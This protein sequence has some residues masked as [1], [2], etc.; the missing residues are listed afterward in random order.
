MLRNGQ[1]GQPLG[2]RYCRSYSTGA[3]WM[4]QGRGWSSLFCYSLLSNSEHQP[5]VIELLIAFFGRQYFDWWR[6]FIDRA[7]IYS[8][9]HT[10]WLVRRSVHEAL[11][12]GMVQLKKL[13]SSMIEVRNAYHLS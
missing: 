11:Q 4:A 5:R 12:C 3:I 9:Y 1:T 6:H 7:E 13:P 8:P 10:H 2:P